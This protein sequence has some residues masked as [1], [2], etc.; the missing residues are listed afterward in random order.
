MLEVSENSATVQWSSPANN[1]G[2]TVTGYVVQRRDVKRPVW[3]K[4]G[5]VNADQLSFKIRDLAEGSEYAVQVFAE[6][7]EGLSEPL[8]SERP[9]A[10]RRAH[11]PPARPASLECIGV[12]ASSVTVQWE[13]PLNVGGA[14]IKGIRLE[15]C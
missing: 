11:G 5:R 3:V 9:V 2:A 14:L 6:N 4:C 10:P 8:E 12:D 7:V 15:S 13:Q 1:G